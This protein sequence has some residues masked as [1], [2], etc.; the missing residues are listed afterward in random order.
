MIIEVGFCEYIYN[1]FLS[2]DILDVNVGVLKLFVGACQVNT[3]SPADES[4]IGAAALLGGLGGHL[5][6]LEYESKFSAN[7]F[8][9]DEPEARQS[10]PVRRTQC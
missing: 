3:A 8:Q 7:R 1:L 4:E 9:F 2:V 6:V 5:V 10:I